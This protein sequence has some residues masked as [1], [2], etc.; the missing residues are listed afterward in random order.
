MGFI[1]ERLMMMMMVSNFIEEICHVRHVVGFGAN[2]I[3]STAHKQ[4]DVQKRSTLVTST[5]FEFVVAHRPRLVQ[6]SS[7]ARSRRGNKIQ[8]SKGE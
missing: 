4:D 7:Q 1:H 3:T 6:T 5:L 8:Y 2:S